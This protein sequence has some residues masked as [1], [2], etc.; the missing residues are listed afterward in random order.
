MVNDWIHSKGIYY[1]A[2]LAKTGVFMYRLLLVGRAAMAW[3]LMLLPSS[4]SL[5]GKGRRPRVCCDVE[6]SQPIILHHRQPRRVSKTLCFVG[7][8]KFRC[9][10]CRSINKRQPVILT[11]TQSRLQLIDC[12]E[13]KESWTLLLIICSHLLTTSRSS[14]VQVSGRQ[15]VG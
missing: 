10:L 9:V 4:V 11:L 13:T 8:G 6:L 14:H 5:R 7:Q 3:Y 12:C 1:I 2:L 15:H